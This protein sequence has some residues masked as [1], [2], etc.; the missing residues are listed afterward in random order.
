MRKVDIE[1]SI[2]IRN[3]RIAGRWLTGREPEIGEWLIIPRVPSTSLLGDRGL[4]R[5]S[6]RYLGLLKEISPHRLMDPCTRANQIYTSKLSL[7]N[8]KYSVQL[9]PFGDVGFLKHRLPCIAR[10]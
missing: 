4:H 10:D 6:T 8:I 1:E 7:R 3:G 5:L 2:V 9:S